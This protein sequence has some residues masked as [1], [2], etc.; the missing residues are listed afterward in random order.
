MQY[1]FNFQNHKMVSTR[2][3][4]DGQKCRLTFNYDN[5]DAITLPDLPERDST[6]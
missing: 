4:I 1:Y 6:Y 5:I 3:I 2:A